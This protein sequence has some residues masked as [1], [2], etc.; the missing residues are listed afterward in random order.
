MVEWIL[1]LAVNL[2][3][4]SPSTMRDVSLSTTSGFTSQAKCE[5]A[6]QKIAHRSIA[7]IGHAREQRGIQPGSRTAMPSVNFECVAVQK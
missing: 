5:A 4:D 6:G 7:V 2:I 3:G 1:V